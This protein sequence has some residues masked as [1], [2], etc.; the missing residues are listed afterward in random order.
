MNRRLIVDSGAELDI[1]DGFRWYEARRPGLGERFLDELDAAFQRVVENPA[2]YQQVVSEVRR[3]V[4]RIYPY[5]VFFT[6]DL[7]AVHISA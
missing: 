5:L 6:F 2:A 3:A 4:V 7:E 1:G